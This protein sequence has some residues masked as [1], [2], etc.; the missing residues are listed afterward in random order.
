MKESVYLIRFFEF[1][2]KYYIK[3][4]F[5]IIQVTEYRL[6]HFLYLFIYLFMFIIRAERVL[7]QQYKVIQVLH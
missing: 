2:D 7:R 6:Y 1:Y 4:R 5:Y 3:F